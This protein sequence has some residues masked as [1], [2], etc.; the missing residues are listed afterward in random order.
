MNTVN[1]FSP[2]IDDL[3]ARWTE[4]AL[5]VLK[6]A[7]MREISV[8]TELETWHMLKKMLRSALGADCTPR[9]RVSA[10]RG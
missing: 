6:A 2:S 1:D 10:L 8:D 9:F 4:R 7:G 5:D 3:A